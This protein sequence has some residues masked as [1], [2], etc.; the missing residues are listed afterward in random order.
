MNY[1]DLTIGNSDTGESVTLGEVQDIQLGILKEF[2]RVCDMNDIPFWLEYGT[3]LGAVRHQGFIPWDDD[4]DISVFQ[5]DYPRLVQ[6][7]EK[8]LD[9]SKY[10]YHSFETNK[11][12][13]VLICPGK[14]RDIRT[15]AKEPFH[16]APNDC[17]SDGLFI[18]VFVVDHCSKDPKKD[19]RA[20]FINNI[21][22]AVMMI[23]ANLH[24][25][26][27][28]AKRF[29]LWIS[30]RY[31]KKYQN[32]GV[33][34]MMTSAS[35]QERAY[36]TKEDIFPLQECKFEDCIMYIPHNP[37]LILKQYYNDYMS[38]PPEKD[39]KFRHVGKRVNIDK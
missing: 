37:D 30:K 25:H 9:K 11:K 32:D 18:D 15:D 28:W 17:A 10:I 1:R 38:L 2:K 20:V 22:A 26:I 4:I 12:Y 7:L 3:M 6:A 31:S 13:N 29:H 35:L 21:W 24:I 23:L 39:R 34:S 36:F 27:N 16:F 8:D 33:Y 5:E 19:K 14:V